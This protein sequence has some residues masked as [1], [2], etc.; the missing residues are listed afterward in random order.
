LAAF[1]LCAGQASREQVQLA[2]LGRKL[3]FELLSIDAL[4]LGEDEPASL[5]RS[6]DQNRRVNRG[7]VLDMVMPQMSGRAAY[8]ALRE[9]DPVPRRS[10]EA[11]AEVD[12]GKHAEWRRVVS[13]A[14]EHHIIRAERIPDA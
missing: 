7:I 2:Q 5:S 4:G 9:I 12:R 11:V 10:L 3:E 14:A 6:S 1:W 13:L 8:V